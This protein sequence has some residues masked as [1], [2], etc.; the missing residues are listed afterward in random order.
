LKSS[1]T[2]RREERLWNREVFR[3]RRER[4]GKGEKYGKKPIVPK[5]K[6]RDLETKEKK[7]GVF[8]TILQEL[9]H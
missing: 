6:S 4:T 5:E 8:G 2:A 9:K 7:L 1:L 3:S